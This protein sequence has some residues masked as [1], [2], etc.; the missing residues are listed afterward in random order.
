MWTRIRVAL[1]SL[2]VQFGIGFVFAMLLVAVGRNSAVDPGGQRLIEVVGF[3]ALAFIATF[4][5]LR[6]VPGHH[7]RGPAELAAALTGPVLYSV[8]NLAFHASG[9]PAGWVL[10]G[11]LAPLVLGVA[12]VFVSERARELDDD[13]AGAQRSRDYWENR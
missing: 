5:A 6:T 10:A 11:T 7:A 9:M 2:G 4:L 1:V 12:G 8:A 13:R 3:A